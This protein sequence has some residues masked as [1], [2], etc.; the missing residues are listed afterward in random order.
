MEA[1]SPKSGQKILNTKEIHIGKNKGIEW[2]V[3]SKTSSGQPVM[4]IIKAIEQDGY[5]MAIMGTA[6]KM[7]WAE[8]EPILRST[9]SSFKSFTD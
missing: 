8:Y 6:L 9:I 5:I 7:H 2:I 3:T 1:N 4:Q